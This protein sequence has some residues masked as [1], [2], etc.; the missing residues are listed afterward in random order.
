MVQNSLS[1]N[2]A[3]QNSYVY[4]NLFLKGLTFANFVNEQFSKKKK[5]NPPKNRIK[6]LETFSQNTECV[7]KSDPQNQVYKK[8]IFYVL[9]KH[10]LS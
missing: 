7:G 6:P 9:S 8:F 3:V 10:R 5:K 2:Y 4:K 1:Q